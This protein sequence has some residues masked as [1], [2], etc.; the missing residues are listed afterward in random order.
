MIGSYPGKCNTCEFI[1]IGKRT[2]HDK[3]VA[4]HFT[5]AHHLHRSGLFMGERREYKAQVFSALMQN[6]EHPSIMS[7]I[8]DG[9]DQSSCTCPFVGTQNKFDNP[10]PMHFTGVKEHGVHVTLYR[11]IGTVSGKSPDLTIYCILNQLEK[12]KTRNHGRYPEKIYV[13]LDGGIE[14]QI[15]MC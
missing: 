4:A 3:T 13:Q 8:I 1:E 2:S 15:I 6:W 5:K 11:T 14:N 7:I 12:W 10:F 9:M